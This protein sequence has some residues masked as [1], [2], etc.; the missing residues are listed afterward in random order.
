MPLIQF[1]PDD[2]EI[3]ACTGETVLAASLRAGIS[4]P[5]SVRRPCAMLTCRIEIQHRT[6][7]LRSDDGRGTPDGGA[8]ALPRLRHPSAGH[9]DAA[10]NGPPLS[11]RGSR[12]VT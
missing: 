1:L 4:A 12:S 10:C 6:E 8:A 11:K 2:I 5:P 7:P 3:D 9:T